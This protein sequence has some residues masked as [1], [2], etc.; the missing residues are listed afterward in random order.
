MM[1]RFM[2]GRRAAGA[3]AYVQERGCCKEAAGGLESP[4]SADFS[5]DPQSGQMAPLSVGV[6]KRVLSLCAYVPK[7]P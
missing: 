5:G 6:P 3:A 7:V 2:I 4:R 1:C